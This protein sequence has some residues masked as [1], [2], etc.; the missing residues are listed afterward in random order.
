MEEHVF[1]ERILLSNLK[2]HCQ[3]WRFVSNSQLSALDENGLLLVLIWPC[4]IPEGSNNVFRVCFYIN[5]A[6]LF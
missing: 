3:N 6:Y 5:D 4:E 2:F 1:S